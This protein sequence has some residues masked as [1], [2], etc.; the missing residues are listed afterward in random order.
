MRIGIDGGS[1]SNRRGYGR[2]LREIVHAITRIPCDHDFTVFLDAATAREFAPLPH[3]QVR[4]VTLSRSV[5]EAATSDGNRS[6]GD[7]FRMG[8][9]VSKEPL[10][11]FF[12]PTVYS[13]FPLWTRVPAVVGIHDTIADR[14]PHFSFATKRQ[15][16]L[17]KAKVR[18][19]LFQARLVMTV[20]EYSSRCLQDHYKVPNSRIRVVPEA[21]SDRFEAPSLNSSR[22]PFVLYVGGISPNKNLGTLIRAFAGLPDDRRSNWRLLLAGDYKS[23]GF[24]NCFQEMS[25]LVREC[26]LQERVEFLGYVSDDDLVRL[27]QRASLFVMPSLDEGFGL[28]AVEAMAS[29]TPVIVSDGNSLTEVVGSA[30]IL[31][32]AQDERALSDHMERVISNPQLWDHMSKLGIERAASFSWDHAARVLL[33]ILEEAGQARL[34]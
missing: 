13:Y 31:F 3:F 29:G 28:P 8:R 25:A 22:E 27:Y 12:Y 14:N 9:A 21:A 23:D 5:S 16:F 15:E 33:N 1:W 18:M 19:A 10:D 32:P 7:L 26:G 17:W 34:L 11:V 6:P 24:Q 20:S 30:G 2:F 4:E